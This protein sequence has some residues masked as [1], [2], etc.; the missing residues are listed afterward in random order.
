V[1]SLHYVTAYRH[2]ANEWWRFAITAANPEAAAQRFR[3]GYSDMNFT[4]INAVFIC[5]TAA[6]VFQEL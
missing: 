4:R 3:D 6:D 2:D 5:E 1:N